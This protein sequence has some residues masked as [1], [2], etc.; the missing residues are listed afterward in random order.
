MDNPFHRA[1][2]V[3]FA[4]GIY[5]SG[6][7]Q[8]DPWRQCRFHIVEGPHATKYV[9]LRL[10]WIGE[11]RWEPF[12]HHFT[13]LSGMNPEEFS[14]H[15]KQRELTTRNQKEAE[16]TRLFMA[17]HYHLELSGTPLSIRSLVERIDSIDIVP[18][19][20]IDAPS[21]MSPH[22][23]RA[24]WQLASQL[25]WDIEQLKTVVE[26]EWGQP[27]SQADDDTATD[28]VLYLKDLEEDARL[29]RLRRE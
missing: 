25:Q 19:K 16:F 2:P 11:T 9:D 29:V 26:E 27:L 15:C 8:G 20:K 3:S 5:N 18:A 17:S 14:L 21:L 1:T 22:N 13:I 7:F 6:R 4:A 23:K 12:R 24:I 28:I 10:P